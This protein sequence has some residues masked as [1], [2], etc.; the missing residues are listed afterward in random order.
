MFVSHI[1]DIEKVRIGNENVKGI[2]KQVLIGPPQGWSD[3]VM[4]RFSLEKGGYAPRH[5]HPWPHITYI[6]EGEGTLFLD[7]TEYPLTA[8]SVSY[9]PSDGDHQIR[10]NEDHPLVFLC[11]VPPEGDK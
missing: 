6:L 10:A 9:I 2:T 4:R 7:G 1:D 3:Y 5:S 8:G 11:I